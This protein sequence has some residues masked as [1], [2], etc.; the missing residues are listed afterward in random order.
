VVTDLDQMAVMV[1]MGYLIQ[2]QGVLY[3]M[4]AAAVVVS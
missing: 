3:I 4:A 1:V 2:F